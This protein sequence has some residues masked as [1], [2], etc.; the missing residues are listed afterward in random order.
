MELSN[1]E[2]QFAKIKRMEDEV[3]AKMSRF[4][5]EQHRIEIMEDDFKKL[6]ATSRS[7]EEKLSSLTENNDVLQ[8]MQLKFRK[9][10]DA[11]AETEEKYQRIEKKNQILDATNEGI[12][13]NFKSLQDSEKTAGQFITTVEHLSIELTELKNAIDNLTR[14]NSKAVETAEKLSSLDVQLSEIEKRIADMQKARQWL[15]DLET[16][17]NDVNR[18]A[19]SQVKLAGELIKKENSR[20][21][22]TE[23]GAPSATVREDVIALK[24]KGWTID[25]I[26]R[27]LKL[28][29]GV[30]ELILET[31]RDR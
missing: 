8:E 27:S 14:E 12:D 13:K 10:S 28:S 4:L 15:A 26:S 19:H 2:N 3:N 29:K 31:P 6:L 21:S 20:S 18:E 23:M 7:V 5:A 17:M 30:V 11:I 24:R 16:R 9:L 22:F 1:V 25:E